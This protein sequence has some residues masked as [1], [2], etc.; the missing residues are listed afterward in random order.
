MR[1]SKN[2]KRKGLAFGGKPLEGYELLELLGRI[3]KGLYDSKL[4][5]RNRQIPPT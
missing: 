2:S 1:Q 3:N 4:E 5:N